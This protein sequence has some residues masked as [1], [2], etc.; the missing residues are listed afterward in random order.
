MEIDISRKSKFLFISC[1][2]FLYGLGEAFAVCA[3][4]GLIVHQNP[5]RPESMFA[6]YVTCFEIGQAA[7]KYQCPE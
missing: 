4:L 3:A 7:G 6:L 5:G 2:R 1:Y